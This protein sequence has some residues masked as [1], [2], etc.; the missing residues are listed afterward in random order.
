[1]YEIHVRNNANNTHYA[2]IIDH[3]NGKALY[4]QTMPKSSFGG[5]GGYSG[6]IFGKGRRGCLFFGG[7]D[8]RGFGFRGG[9]MRGQPLSLSQSSPMGPVS[10]GW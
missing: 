6:G 7:D 1:V 3:G 5:G 10:P 2:I 9:I 8:D 4:K